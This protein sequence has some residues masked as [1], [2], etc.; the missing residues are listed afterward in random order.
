MKY[1]IRFLDAYKHNGVGMWGITIENE[2]GAGNS[3]DYGWNSLGFT[4]DQQR[5]FVKKDLGPALSKAGFGKDVLSVMIYDDQR[6]SMIDWANI[7]N[8]KDAAQYIHGMAYHWYNSNNENLKNLDTVH[9]AHPDKYIMSTESSYP[10]NDNEP[11]GNWNIAES[12]TH[13]II[14]VIH[15]ND[16]MIQ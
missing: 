4:R 7:Y 11:I 12:Y 6:P 8:D 13:D 2:P 16:I 3:K 9:N 14:T 1:I 10:F 5:D 15:I